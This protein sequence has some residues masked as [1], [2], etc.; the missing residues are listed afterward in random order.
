M[1]P[2]IYITETPTPGLRSLKALRESI[3]EGRSKALWE[4]I[5]RHT[6][7][8]LAAD[9]L[10]PSSDFPGRDATSRRHANRDWT[11]CKAA[12]DRLL[13]SALTAL[14]ANDAAY[15]TPALRQLEALYGYRLWAD[16]RDAAHLMVSADLRTGMLSRDVGLAYDWMYT[17]LSEEQRGWIVAGLKRQGFDPFWKSVEEEAFWANSPN[18]WMTCI[19]GGLG[20][21]AMAVGDA[22]P[23]YGEVIDY[24]LPRILEYRR[25]F[26]SE[27]EFNESVFY[28]NATLYPVAYLMAHRYHSG[29]GEDLIASWPF[30]ESCSWYMHFTVP[31]VRIVDFGDANVKW[32]PAAAYF[33]AVAQTTRDPVLQ[34]YYLEH[35]A[36]TL[37]GVPALELLWFDE[38]LAPQSP[39]GILPRGRAFPAHSGCISSRTDWNPKSTACVVYAKAGHGAEGHGNHDAGQVCIDGHGERLIVDL[40]SPEMYPKDY[41]ENRYEYYNA[42]A[43]G[44]NVLIFGGREMR[45]SEDDRA[46]ILSSSFDDAKGGRWTIDLTGMYEGVKSVRRTVVHLLPGVVAVYDEAELEREEDISLRWH[47]V[48]QAEPDAEGAFTVRGARASLSARVVRL[49]GE[50]SFARGQH[51]YRPPFNRG[52]L[53]DVFTPRNESYVEISAVDSRCRL[54]SLFSVFGPENELAAWHGSGNEWRIETLDGPVIVRVDDSKPSAERGDRKLA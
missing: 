8:D 21:A 41:G 36:D 40:G 51:E 20:I 5:L 14:I 6:E 9:P 25:N 50:A 7:A 47:T 24:S 4:S 35:A 28:S 31:P 26:G 3:K 22:Y 11:I 39:E 23:R 42:A 54:L 15:L 32:P 27:G 2:H 19:V 53:G 30:P 17:L 1:H 49:D 45:R 29:G 33:A 37:L 44:H 13:N 48:D 43:S 10:L 52:R 46:E 18:N 34:W 12:G 38:T 16:W